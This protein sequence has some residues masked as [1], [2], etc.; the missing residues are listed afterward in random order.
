MVTIEP[1]GARAEAARHL[2]ASL[3]N[4][5][6]PRGDWHDVLAH[7]PFDLLFADGGDAKRREPEAVLEAMRPGQRVVLDDLRPEGSEPPERRGT[8]DPVRA[9]GL[10]APRMVATEAVVGPNMAVILATCVV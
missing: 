7:G 9:D 3:P 2:V 1:D 6:V 8:P 10:N 4:V 5:R